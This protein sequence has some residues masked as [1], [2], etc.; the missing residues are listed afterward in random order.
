MHRVE[1]QA[2]LTRPARRW[3]V[4]ALCAA[5]WPATVQASDRPFL[6]T[7]NAAAEEDDDRVWA[8]ETWWQRIGSQRGFT[9]GPEYAFN[10]T[11]SI[12]FELS[13]ASGNAKAAEA[14][15]KHLFNHIGR[16]GWGWGI[17]VSLGLA[18]D[19]DSG[20]R[21]H[22][23]SVKVPYSLQ[24]RGGEALLHLNVGLQK[25]RGE[26]R[27]GVASAAFEH[28][29]PWRST[30]FVE[31]GREDRHTLWHAGVRHWI[32]RDKLALDVSAQQ[33]RGGGDKA[34]GMVV[35]VAWYDL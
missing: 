28:K 30:A 22:A 3:L 9:V 34:G 16:D 32:R 31:V 24:L 1:Q 10:P 4:A 18:S 19:G 35:G 8:V 6:L 25:R 7:S 2:S 14:E 27:E 26:R 29:L 20:W 23:V 33:L 21:Q 15:F 17:D 12:Q 5:S 11:T 13:R